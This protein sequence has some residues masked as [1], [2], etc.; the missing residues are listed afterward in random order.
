MKDKY[1][2]LQVLYNTVKNVS[3]PL[4]YH[5]SMR[6]L[7]LQVKGDWQPEY[8]EELARDNLVIVKRT[9]TGVVIVLTEKGW[10]TC[11]LKFTFPRRF[12]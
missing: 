11:K 3:Q 7:L 8:L 2:I 5:C 1:A 12:V 10:Q 9:A 4:Q 6:E